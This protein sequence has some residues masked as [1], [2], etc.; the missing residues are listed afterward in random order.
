MGVI[1]PRL[2]F[3][4]AEIFAKFCF[5]AHDFGSRYARKTVKDSKD[6]DHSLVS[7]N[8]LNQQMTY[9][10]GVQSR[11]KVAK[12]TQNHPHCDVTPREPEIQNE[13][14]F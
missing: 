13:T 14:I 11:V 9:W 8:N 1:H 3:V 7:K 4:G 12:K 2:A 6:A 5:L 10:I